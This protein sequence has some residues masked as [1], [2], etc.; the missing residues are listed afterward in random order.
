[1]DW[2]AI[3]RRILDGGRLTREEGRA[4]LLAPDEE[5]LA[6]IGAA[7]LLRRRQHGNLVRVHV[8]ENAKSDACPEDCS[9]CSQSVHY[10]TEVSR[11]RMRSVDELVAGAEEAV[12]KGAVTY[13]MVTA[14]R[15]PNP[16]ELE[17]IC[18]AT[19]RIKERFPIR[20]CASLGLLANGQAETL[21]AA[22]V[23]R[24]NHNL[25]TSRRH[26]P[27]VCSSHGFEDRVATIRAAHAAGME[28]CC[29]GIMGMG[30]SIDDRLDLAFE[31]AELRVESIPINFLDPRAGTPLGDLPRIDPREALR[32]LALVRLACP[33]ALDVRL[34][35]GREVVLGGLQPLALHVANSIFSDGY[36]TTG[37]Q[38]SHRDLEMIREAGFEPEV[39]AA[40]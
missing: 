4:A 35:G 1:M 38:G 34:A 7:G 33:E 19:R 10:Q 21:A 15:G 6:L 28:A 36:L 26:F 14:T 40:T 29:G 20:I 31:L 5:L 11:Y 8:L 24:Y 16:A 18:E 32:A 3:G 25:E 17:T 2:H 13:C 27:E 39:L 23:D 12:A 22:G 30:E 9:F 37:G